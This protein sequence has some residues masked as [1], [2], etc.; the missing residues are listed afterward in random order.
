MP[1]GRLKVG[2]ALVGAPVGLLL[3][4]LGGLYVASGRRLGH[5]FSEQ[6]P[7]TPLAV[8]AGD[9]GRGEHLFEV[10]FGCAHCHLEDGSG[11]VLA[12]DAG[13]GRIQAANL[14]SGQGSRLAGY[15]L[16]AFARAVRHGVRR[17]GTSVIFMPSDAYVRVSDQEIADLWAYVHALPPVDRDVPRPSP[18]PVAR[19]LFLAGELPMLASAWVADHEVQPPVAPPAVTDAAAYGE[20][21][22]QACLGCHGANL[23]GGPIPG[24]P[25]GWPAAPNISPSPDGIGAWTEEDFTKTLQT[26]V[27][28]KGVALRE[29]M[30]TVAMTRHTP[31]EYHALW[32]FVRSKPGV[33]DNPGAGKLDR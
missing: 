5:D 20:H 29:P 4:S 19:A 13:F 22:G 12:D 26:L 24:A 15:D 27:N 7:V 14:T 25:P 2:A 18:G 10:V 30:A 9:T 8:T 1:S 21:I 11:K 33:P 16:P 31:E 6:V 32:S 3:V 23:G 28:P 17:D